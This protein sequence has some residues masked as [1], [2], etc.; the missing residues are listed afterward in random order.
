M[1]INFMTEENK[2]LYIYYWLLLI[3]FLVAI[4][5]IVGGLTRLTDSGLSITEWDLF[6]GIL[7]PLTLSAWEMYFNLYKE[8]SEYKLINSSMTLDE[9]KVIF[10]WEY[11]HRLLGRFIGLVYVLPLVYFSFKKFLNKKKIKSLYF[12][13]FLILIQG[14]VGWYM[15]QS[16]LTERT[17]VSHFRLS[18]HLTLAFVIY[19]LLV[20]N[21]LNY[22]LKQIDKFNS[23]LPYNL[24]K[25]FLLLVLIQISI[26]AFVSGLDAGQIY[27]TWPLMNFNYFPDDS[28]LLDLFSVKAFNEP[29]LV[30]F[31]HRNMAYLIIFVFSIIFYLVFK[32]EK[33]FYLKKIVLYTSILL[34]FQVFFGVL[35]VIKGAPIFLASLHQL[36]SILLITASLVLVYKNS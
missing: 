13:F 34:L 7:P 1:Y 21:I 12:I 2:N 6:E 32:F 19:I 23:F 11:I 33:F 3:T 17:D 24:S 25:F 27:N 4:M 9:F 14:F 18:L 26:G 31:I 16:G 10:W 15:V 8:T 30:Q 20:W 5:I 22:R 28:S 36:G 29:S 35:T